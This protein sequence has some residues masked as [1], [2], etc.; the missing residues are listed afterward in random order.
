MNKTDRH[1]ITEILL[2]VALN[3]INQ[4]NQPIFSK[5]DFD[6]DLLV[7]FRY[8]ISNDLLCLVCSKIYFGP[9]AGQG[10]VSRS[11]L[12]LGIVLIVLCKFY[13]TFNLLLYIV[14]ESADMDL[15]LS[16]IGSQT[17]TLSN[18]AARH[19]ISVKRNLLKRRPSGA[20]KSKDNVCIFLLCAKQI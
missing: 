8:L 1:D 4:L 18:D 15:D 2:K 16:A 6:V 17:I 11:T 13:L 20:R 5:N 19:R 7:P 10:H 12:H 14:S 3:S 9:R